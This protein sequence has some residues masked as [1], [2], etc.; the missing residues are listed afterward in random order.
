MASFIDSAGKFDQQAWHDYFAALWSAPSQPGYA[1]VIRESIAALHQIA[2]TA[3]LTANANGATDA[4]S[5]AAEA[6]AQLPTYAAIASATNNGDE[7]K[8]HVADPLLTHPDGA[9]MKIGLALPLLMAFKPLRT[10]GQI[11]DDE[12]VEPTKKFAKAGGLSLLAIAG[13]ALGAFLA[14]RFL[15]GEA[16]V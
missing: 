3:H 12:V 1:T 8:K 4:A 9:L 10:W 15:G 13:I 2:K 11:F 5:Y 14:L 6:L 16:G 7:L